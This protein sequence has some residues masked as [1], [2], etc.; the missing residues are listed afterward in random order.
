MKIPAQ[1]QTPVRGYEF[2]RIRTN[3]NKTYKMK[4]KNIQKNIL[5]ILQQATINLKHD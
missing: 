3:E 5:N 1:T 4:N 2:P